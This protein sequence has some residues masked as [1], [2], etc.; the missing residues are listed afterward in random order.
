MLRLQAAASKADEFTKG[1][2]QPGDRRRG[3]RPEGRR[4]VFFCSGKVYYDL[5]A[6]RQKRGLTDTAI[7]RVERL[8]PL[9]IDEIQSTLSS[10]P[11]LRDLRWAQE[12]PANQ[13]AWPFMALNLPEHLGNHLLYRVSRPASSSP[14]CGSGAVHEAEQQ[15]LVEQAFA[16]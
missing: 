7:V 3:G 9:P 14:A 1:S 11:N 13:G 5:D 8:Y 12:E 6:E 2:F 15:A 16:D 4:D 10:Y